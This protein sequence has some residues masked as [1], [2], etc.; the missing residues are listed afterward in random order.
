M[1]DQTLVEKI[2]R[3]FSIS[4]SVNEALRIW[5]AGEKHPPTEARPGHSVSGRR[6]AE[7]HTMLDTILDHGGP[8]DIIGIQAN[9]RWGAESVSKRRPHPKRHAG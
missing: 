8:D 5:L 4:D 9:L 7:W 3:T 6:H 1:L 2:P